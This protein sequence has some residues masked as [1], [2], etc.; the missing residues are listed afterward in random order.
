VNRTLVIVLTLV[1]AIVHLVV[2]NLNGVQPLFVLNGLGY[3]ALLGAWLW[4]FPKGQERLVAYA[5]IAYTAVT[6]LAW[7][8]MGSRGFLGYGTKAVEVALIYFLWRSLP[9]KK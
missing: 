2:L 8:F 6:I 7:V 1:T 4:N 5:F 9:S 3:F